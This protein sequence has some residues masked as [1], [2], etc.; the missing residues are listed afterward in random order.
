[1]KGQVFKRHTD[2]YYVINK[3]S[4]EVYECKRRERLKK[5]QKEVVVGDLVEFDVVNEE[6]Q[7]GVIT[8]ILPRKSFITRPP[9]A[10]IDQNI[11]I[12]SLREPLLDI[13]QLD[14]FIVHTQ[15]ANLEMVVFINKMDLKDKKK[16]LPQIKEIYADLNI[17]IIEMS[18]KM[19][20]NLE[21]LAEKLKNKKT[22]FS[23]PSGVG[24]STIINLL[25]PDANLK[26]N[27]VSSKTQRG[28]HTT[29]HVEL[30]ELTFDDGSTATIADSPGFSYLKFDKYLPEE[31]KEQ[32][33]EF[34]PY[35]DQCYFADCMHITEEDC[36]VKDNLDKISQSRYIS[37]C[38]F[39]EEAVEYKNRISTRSIKEES[40]I[41]NI[42]SKGTSSKKRLKLGHQ[43]VESSRKT[44][45]QKLSSITYVE[46]I[47]N[48]LLNELE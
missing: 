43:L 7:Q 39:V 33:P 13:S 20:L 1:M 26:T 45:K 2:F 10:N 12:M 6:A 15:L 27:Y 14:R 41:K 17:E 44:Y 25:K 5:E 37:Y 40:N 24:K 36:A 30:F 28:M 9:I 22:V 32:F 47:E 16:L 38:K 8:T 4:Q 48:D 31:I 35:E 18:A 3:E 46:D 11:I 23:G 34:K 19:H 21:L 29:R 42:D